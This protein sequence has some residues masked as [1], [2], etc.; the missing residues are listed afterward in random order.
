MSRPV[1]PFSELTIPQLLVVHNTLARQCGEPTKTAWHGS[2]MALIQRVAILRTLPFKLAKGEKPK[3]LRAKR[4]RMKRAAPVRM[5]I[6]KA[7]SIVSHY[8]CPITGNFISLRTARG[9]DT[10]KLNSVG[11]HYSDVLA[12]VLARFPESKT[13]GRDL[14]WTQTQARNCVPGFEGFTM[15]TKRPH[16]NK[17]R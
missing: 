5:A 15:P 9:M 2:R 8:E 16:T 4:Q 14:R 13:T 17:E 1:I 7:L 10:S 11:R 3:T 12:D 6:L